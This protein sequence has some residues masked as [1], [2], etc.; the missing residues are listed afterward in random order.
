MATLNVTVNG[1]KYALACKDGDE[2]KLR[3]LANFVDSR[4]ADLVGKLGHVNETKL[5]LMTAIIIADEYQESL[6]G[7]GNNAVNLGALSDAD[8]AAVLNHIT[9]EID[10]IAGK[11][12]EA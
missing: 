8:V 1:N 7:T 5:L 2:E 4:A 9:A 10:G 12:A 3:N 11:L 6:S